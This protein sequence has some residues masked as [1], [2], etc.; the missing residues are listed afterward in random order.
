[1]RN[2]IL[3]LGVLT[4]ICCSKSEE[5][6]IAGVWDLQ[7]LLIDGNDSTE[8][9]KSQ[10]CYTRMKFLTAKEAEGKAN[11]LSADPQYSM[12]DLRGYYELH[13]DYLLLQVGS[14]NFRPI[15]AFWQREPR[16]KISW[17]ILKLTEDELQLE[18]NF[19]DHHNR[20]SLIK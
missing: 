20:L 6:L 8:A 13:D 10:D 5:K 17:N 18:T 3:I 1:M 16:T 2:L 15:G 19:N 9:A 14:I 11:I 7:Q 12:C 4:M